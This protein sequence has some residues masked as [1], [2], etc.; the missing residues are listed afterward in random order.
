MEA[1]K[2]KVCLCAYVKEHLSGILKKV[3]G[4]GR[5]K[6]SK[7]RKCKKVVHITRFLRQ[8]RGIHWVFTAMKKTQND[9]TKA[10]EIYVSEWKVVM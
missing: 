10:S 4:Q 7:R 5:L 6:P 1:I 3:Y 9:M 8:G 2:I